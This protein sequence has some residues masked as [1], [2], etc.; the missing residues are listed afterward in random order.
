MSEIPKVNIDG[1]L[2]V[3]RDGSKVP[4]PV[5]NPNGTDGQLLRSNGDGTTEW[6]DEGTPTDEQVGEAV[7]DWLTDHPEATTT[8]QNGSITK[9]KL[10]QDMQDELSGMQ[11]DIADLKTASNTHATKNEVN[12]KLNDFVQSIEQSPTGILVTFG[13]ESTEDIPIDSG[14]LAFDGGFVQQNEE[15][16]KFYLHLT[17]DGEEIEDFN[18]IE[19]PATGGGGTGS[20]SAIV[21]TNVVKHTAVRNGADALFGF[22]A[23]SSDDTGIMARWFVDGVQVSTD[24]KDSGASFSFNAKNYLRPSDTSIVQVTIS[25]ES[26][27]SL[28]RKWTVTSTAFSLSWGAAI[29]PI[30]LY[31]ANEDIYAVVNVTA[32]GGTV[33]NV[34]VT[35]NGH[36]VTRSVTG[37][38]ALTV[39]LDKSWFQLGANTVTASMVSSTDVTDTAEDIHYVALWGYGTSAPVVAFAKSAQ[40]GT[41]YDI[42]VIHYFVYDPGNETAAASIQF[43][44]ETA[45]SLSASR[46]MQTYRHAP[47]EDGTVTVTLR[48][49][50]SSAS[51]TL[52]VEPSAYNIGMVS[53]D[54]LRYH[55]DPVGHS[56]ADNDRDQFGG[57]T[58][59]PGFDWVNGGFQTDGDGAS[60]FV[61]K[62]G[63]RAT[64]PRSLFADSDTNG[65]MIHLS[66]KITNSDQYDAVAMQDM[67][68]GA[69]KGLIL[70]AN[71]GELRL[72]NVSGQS[73]RYCEESRIDLSI[74]VEEVTNQRI[75]TLWLD[76]IPS[77]VDA[78]EANTLVQDENSLVI[79]SDHCDVWIYTI[80]AYNAAFSQQE[81]IQNY[82]SL[83]STTQEKISRYLV[84]NIF[85]S[86]GKITPAT[87]HAAMPGLTVI[88]ISA[89]RMT[90]SKNDPVPADIRITDGSNVI[91]LLAADGTVF[92]VQGTSSVA[93]GRSGYN[94]DLDFKKTGLSYAL[95]SGAIP[96]SYLNVKANIASS[97]NAN[98]I[99]AVDWYNNFQPYL[100]EARENNSAVRD[101]MEGKPCAVFFTNTSDSAVWVSSQLVEPGETILYVMGDL[102]NS[103]K[104]TGVFGQNGEGA[105][106]TKGCVEVSGN[107]TEAQRFRST[108]TYNAEDGEWQTTRI[109]NG[110]TVVTKE[111][112]WRMEPEAEDLDDV[113]AAWDAAVAWAASTVG[114]SA[115]FKREVGNYFAINSLLYHFLAIEFLNA[116]DDVSKNTF[117]SYDW[118]KTEQRYLWN[119]VKAYDWDTILAY[120]NDGKP[121]GDYG[122]DYGDTI[123]GTVNGRSYFNA[124]DN[125][126]WANIKEAFQ[127]ELSAMYISLRSQGAWNAEDMIAKWDNYQNR[128]PHAAMVH[129]AYVKYIYPYKTIGV[130]IDGTTLGYDDNYLSRLAGSKTYQRKQFFT[131]QTAYM[132]GKYGYY[133]KTNSTQFRT[134]GDSSRKDFTVKAYA[135]TYITVLAD[136]SKVASRKVEAGGEAVFA[137]VSVGS[138]TTIYIT[139]DR[140]I[141]RV[142]PL[143]ETQNSTF[144]ASG[145]A[146]LME[147]LLGGETENTAWLSGTGLNIP[148]VILKDLSIRNM[149]NFSGALNLSANV[150]LETLDT[151]GTNA[152]QITLPSY[153]PLT[154]VKLNACTGI[155]AR[156]LNAVEDF[157]LESG[158]NLTSVL[159]EDCN[160]LINEAMLAYL[161][162]ATAAG[163]NATRRIRMIGVN[164]A[165]Q[166]ISTLYSLAT[167][168]KGY[169]ALGEEQNAP[170][171]TGA[172]TVQ[173]W[174]QSKLTAVQAAFPDLTI[175]ANPSGEVPNYTVR[176]LNYD[177]TVLTAAQSIEQGSAPSNPGI[178]PTRA[179]SVSTSYTFD[180]WSWTNG[181]T[182]IDDLSE[183]VITQDSDLYA[184]YTESV[185]T[186]RV[187]WYNGSTLLETQTVNYGA[188]A[189]YSGND[190]VSEAEGDYAMYYLFKGWD[191][192]TGFVAEDLDVYAQYDG[193]VAPS[194]GILSGFTPEQLHA[195]VETE[196]LS[197]TGANNTLVAS[198]DTIDIVAGNDYTFSNVDSHELISLAS[199]QTFDGTN[200]LK[201]QIDGNDILLF[202]TDKS[203]TLAI[204]FAYD[205]TSDAGGC[206]AAC[207]HGNGF[208]LR[209]ASGGSV[210]YGISA[211]QAVSSNGVRQMVVLRKKA[212]ENKLHVYGSNKNAN[213]IVYA[214]LEQASAPSHNAP[215]VFGAQMAEDSYVENYGKGTVYWAKL[216]DGD[217]GDTICR[218]IA[219]WPRQTFKMQAV[220]SSERAFRN[221]TRVD[222]QRYVNCAFLLKELLEETHQMNPTNTNVGGWK[223]A[224]IRTWLNTRLLKALPC[225]WRQMLLTV[226]VHSSAGNKSTSLVDPPAEDKIWIPSTKEMGWEV[227]TTPYAQ[228]SDAPFTVFT[229]NN[230]R[231]K[232][233]NFGAGAA[234]GWWLRSPY[235]GYANGFWST[236]SDGS[237]YYY[238]GAGYSYGI[239]FGFCI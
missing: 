43:G 25:S 82:I 64:L 91:L 20:T 107:D 189:V 160:S 230:S 192:S 34:T 1:R 73:F 10:H 99:C 125:P 37:S 9:Q 114:D 133:S 181:G 11:D 27:A 119:I 208:L 164:W 224:P 188:D 55:L 195:L 239:S 137:N 106:P 85:D 149:V 185:R 202:D 78:Y 205:T 94:M 207:Y 68:N 214:A 168:W 156:H 72:N 102:C 163:G 138:N 128:R 129:D 190:P 120:D 203:F 6:V 187:R 155:T 47:Q 173:R 52:T 80:R 70:R 105:H 151:R 199:P 87:L 8:V 206:L 220:G 84:N 210:R 148:S 233:L 191:K 81:M 201:P 131:Y 113:V 50:M 57:M 176:F 59:S 15:D 5:E 161:N 100:I 111:F 95:S 136:D 23:T 223:D 29:N 123:D 183:V 225:K 66:F 69:T 134:N 86:N 144:S 175:T 150:E 204:D 35:V 92:K 22:T 49:G 174:S 212:G 235:A 147:A 218:D 197:P 121:L 194:S 74:L 211:T 19:I 12:T 182:V 232:R 16:G 4:L 79:G 45:R 179:S 60:A 53:G 172:V 71:E 231:I 93:Y 169:N 180:G 41:Q 146:K 141:Q 152:G 97:E 130:V 166:D 193:A 157:S 132:D 21:L 209:Y 38:R 135:K 7:S 116:Y 153:A 13:D 109:E 124:V 165:I 200:Y 167:K 42:S 30:T 83:G 96:V 56:N 51:M 39:A 145:A 122:L 98:N 216:W 198:G 104:N 46:E 67:N 158:G 76:G 17:A 159:I 44:S 226:Y 178:T 234:D 108:A 112:E 77:K 14:G 88:E 238:A 90:V 65:K 237:A 24:E 26:G 140:L 31:T 89:P 75:V 126:I 63:H 62:K 101:T 222:N 32:Q 28:T 221:F 3:F 177:G 118:D 58:F 110:Q 143:N 36:E 229:D 227:N 103:K 127:P 54:S 186:Y 170:V 18:P 213:A 162:Q 236:Y 142:R 61:V 228:E 219:A 154:S 139:P 2:Y 40:T 215:L 184:H 48:C 196:V 117:Y 33:N 171:L 115:K 217:L